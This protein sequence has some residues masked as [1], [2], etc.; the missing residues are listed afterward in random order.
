MAEI[1]CFDPFQGCPALAFLEKRLDK[2]DEA[3]DK[4]VSLLT[5]QA[6]QAQQLVIQQQ[7][8]REHTEALAAGRDRFNA[9]DLRVA[10]L[11]GACDG[12]TNFKAGVATSGIAAVLSLLAV[13]ASIYTSK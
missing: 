13:A 4:I 1:P 9:M 10:Q 6:V 11:S 2:L 8:I 12:L 3:V 7:M 5:N